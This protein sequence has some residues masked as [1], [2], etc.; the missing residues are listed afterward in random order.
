[1]HPQAGLS[2]GDYEEAGVKRALCRA[3]ADTVVLASP[4]KLATA[5]PFQVVGL[6]Q[7]GTIVVVKGTAEALV[8]PY[9]ERGIAIIEA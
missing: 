2:T 9:R 4:E 5:S 7:V 3:A 6:E 8:Q 1:M